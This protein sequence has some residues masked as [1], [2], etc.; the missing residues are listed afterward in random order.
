MTFFTEDEVATI[1]KFVAWVK[2]DYLAPD[3][4]VTDLDDEGIVITEYNAVSDY[5]SYTLERDTTVLP[6]IALTDPDEYQ[7]QCDAEKAEQERQYEAR[8]Q[9]ALAAREA[10]ERELFRALKAKYE[11]EHGTNA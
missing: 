1:K 6:W 9:T 2:E 4:G 3:E 10:Q 7:R 5:D 11:K 8:R